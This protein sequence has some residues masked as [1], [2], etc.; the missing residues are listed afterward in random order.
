MTINQYCFCVAEATNYTDRDACISD[1]ALSCIF[2]DPEGSDIPATRLDQLGQIWDATH[3]TVKEIAAAT[4]LSCRQLAER[5]GIPYRTMENWSA[6][7][8]ECNLYTRLMMQECLGLL[9]PG[10]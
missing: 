1:L 3:R 8:R 2:G 10:N 4:G 5:F 9:S 7:N 6:G